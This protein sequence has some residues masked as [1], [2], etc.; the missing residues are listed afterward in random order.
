LQWY[1]IAPSFPAL[2]ASSTNAS[3]KAVLVEDI[4]YG[5]GQPPTSAFSANT[6]GPCTNCWL[7]IQF[8]PSTLGTQTAA[9]NLSSSPSGNTS[10]LSTQVTNGGLAS[11]L[12]NGITA[13]GDYATSGTCSTPG[14]ALAPSTSCT[15]QIA[16][17]PTQSG[18]RTG[19]LTIANADADITSVVPPH[20][21]RCRQRNLHPHRQRQLHR[22]RH[23]Q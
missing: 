14:N 20:R 13:T 10:S 9:L 16:F 18:T 6:T 19:T 17:I 2:T 23:R 21:N 3:F 11:V 12:F 5:H 8:Q 22:Q 4:G 15:I 1:K 7:G